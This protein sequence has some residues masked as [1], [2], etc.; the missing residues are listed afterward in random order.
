M[1]KHHR[2]LHLVL[3]LTFILAACSS[4]NLSSEIPVPPNSGST[5]E[6][7][8]QEPTLTPTETPTS[9]PVPQTSFPDPSAYQ[10]VV[11]AEG[12]IRPLLLTNAGDGSNRLFVVE[13]DGI[14][15]VIENGATLAEPFLNIEEN[16]GSGGNEQGLLGLAFHPDYENNGYFYVNYTGLD[17]NTVIARFQV[18]ADPNVAD[19]A[20]ETQL[21]TVAQP[22][23]NHNGGN[24]IFGPDG[25]LYIGLGDGG[26]GGDPQGNGQ[27]LE[28]LLGKMLRIDVNSGEPFA[29]PA[30][31]PFANGGGLPEIWAYGLRNPWRFS[32][33]RSTGDLYIADVGQ[34]QWEEISFLPGGIVGGSNFG[35]NYFEGTHV[36]QGAAPEGASFVPPVTEYDHSG[37]CSVT[38]GFVYR[39]PSLP[40]WTGIYIYGDY[41]SGEVMGL[42]Q[43]PDGAWVSQ[44]LFTQP[45]FITSFGEDEAGELYLVDRNGIIF[46][47]QAN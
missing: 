27:D 35:W 28:T 19:A 29:I 22:Y 47:L 46:Q 38:G 12:F 2:P 3:A 30:D 8:A 31:N 7:A 18:S 17:G 32:F 20:S 5:A 40:E 21:L 16:V 11:I 33:D 23:E 44:V 43:Q 42:F 9:T 6:P 24:L 10:W 36:Y 26:S 1:N 45:S 34:G 39:G 37:R 4:S 15:R 25:Y 41:C 14:I 13:Q